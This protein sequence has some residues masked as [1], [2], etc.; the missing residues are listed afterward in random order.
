MPTSANGCTVL[1]VAIGASLATIPVTALGA[2]GGGIAGSA[3]DF[4]N[5]ADIAVG[6][7]TFC[8]TP[9]KAQS[10][11]L[12]WNHTFSDNTFSWSDTTRTQSG[13]VLPTF[14]KTWNGP[15]PKCLSCHD[16]SVAVGDLAWFDGQPRH[17]NDNIWSE[18][19]G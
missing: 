10:T 16:G 15:T 12:L 7:C 6:A 2:P 19:H 3:H 17:G 5:R 14:T 1:I 18:T 4:T 11:T 9:H 13:T 8:H